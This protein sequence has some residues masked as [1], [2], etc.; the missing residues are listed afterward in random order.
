MNCA[1]WQKATHLL[2]PE[3]KNRIMH[4]LGVRDNLDVRSTRCVEADD[5]SLWML[6]AEL[7]LPD[8]VTGVA[9]KD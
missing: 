4:N 6:Y 3:P 8:S 7:H 2:N 5:E 9:E 1:S